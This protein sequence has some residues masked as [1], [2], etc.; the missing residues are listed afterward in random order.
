[1]SVEEMYTLLTPENRRIVDATIDKLL[2]QQAREGKQHG[3]GK[4]E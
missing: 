4:H 1:M 3:S 2:K